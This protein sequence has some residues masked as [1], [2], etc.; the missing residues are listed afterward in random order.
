M[1]HVDRPPYRY[2]RDSKGVARGQARCAIDFDSSIIPRHSVKRVGRLFSIYQNRD[3]PFLKSLALACLCSAVAKN[4]VGSSFHQLLAHI[5]THPM[6]A[7]LPKRKTLAQ[8]QEKP[9]LKTFAAIEGLSIN[10]FR[11]RVKGYW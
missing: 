3:E 4:L 6:D 9:L 1:Y 11:L 10:G 8:A 5:I 7:K 2:R